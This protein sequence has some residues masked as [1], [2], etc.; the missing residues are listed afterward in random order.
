MLLVVSVVL[1]AATPA[2]AQDERAR[3]L[4][5]E[6]MAALERGRFDEAISAFEGSLELAR[7]STTAY[8]L[9]LALRGSGRIVDSLGIVERI[10]SGEMGDIPSTLRAELDGLERDLRAE[11]AHLRVQV[12]GPEDVELRVDGR[13]IETTQ[14]GAELT[15]DPGPHTL[16][17]TARDHRTLEERVTLRPG[18]HERREL[19]LEA[20]QDHRPGRLVLASDDPESRVEV[21]GVRE[22]PSPLRLE[23]APGEYAVAVIGAHGRHESMVTV[24]PGR[25]V[26]LSLTPPAETP[27]GESPW[28][29]LGVGAGVAALVV[30]GLIVGLS[31]EVNAPQQSA[32]D[33]VIVIGE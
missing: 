32:P 7:R 8:D 23:L 19:R 24:P 1:A 11:A 17:A 30:V 4:F 25:E 28:L 13:Q 14:G 9:A 26:R 33:G 6:G 15:L 27:V 10:T 2:R 20:A 29:W 5:D 18:A 3:A 21:V 31:L 12:Q 22:G 16:V